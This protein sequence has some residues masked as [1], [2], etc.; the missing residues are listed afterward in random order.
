M[1]EGKWST[2]MGLPGI[3]HCRRDHGGRDILIAEYTKTRIHIAHVS[4]AGFGAPDS[5]R[6]DVRGLRNG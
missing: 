1:N 6:Q 2:V 3:L 5:E 4:T